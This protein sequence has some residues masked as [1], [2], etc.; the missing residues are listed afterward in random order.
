MYDAI[1]MGAR[2]AG[3]VT[4][5]L[6]ARRGPKVLLLDRGDIPSDVHQGALHTQT[7]PEATRGLG[8]LGQSG[9]H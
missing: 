2:C 5:M 3:A 6:L 1:V 4:A 8:S 9:G 7:R